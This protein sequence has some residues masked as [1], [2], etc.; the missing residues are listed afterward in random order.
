MQKKATNYSLA[1][2]PKR[3]LAQADTRNYKS[4]ILIQVSGYVDL[5]F[6][7]NKNN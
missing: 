1:T 6:E 4:I 2:K 3:D 7:N 5:S